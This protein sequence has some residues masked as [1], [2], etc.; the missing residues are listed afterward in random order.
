MGLFVSV[1]VSFICL[2]SDL[3]LYIYKNLVYL[4]GGPIFRCGL[5]PFLLCSVCQNQARIQK[6]PKIYIL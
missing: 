1:N 3:R 5:F 2:F 6:F 4:I